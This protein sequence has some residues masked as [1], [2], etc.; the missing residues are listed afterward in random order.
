MVR[1]LVALLLL[2]LPALSLAQD[3]EPDAR[4]FNN[5]LDAF[6]FRAD[7]CA[8]NSSGCGTTTGTATNVI[9]SG[10]GGVR[11]FVSFRVP[12]LQSYTVFFLAPDIDGAMGPAAI[13]SQATALL[14]A[15]ATASV[16]APFPGLAS[17]VYRFTAIVAGSNGRATISQPFQFRYCNPTCVAE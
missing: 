10:T 1:L 4:G 7:V 2:G 17:G 5:V 16:T 3:A 11:G 9:L 14:A 13:V 15:G 6:I 8:G 12:L